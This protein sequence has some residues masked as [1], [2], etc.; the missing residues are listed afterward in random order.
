MI[1]LF[2]VVAFPVFAQEEHL[3][4][5]S[6][7]D[8]SRVSNISNISNLQDVIINREQ[9][10]G[11]P[12]MPTDPGRRQPSAGT[13]SGGDNQPR[14]PR[15]RREIKNREFD[16]AEKI[17]LL[18]SG[19]CDFPTREDLLNTSQNANEIL[20]NIVM[21]EDIL[22]SVRMR[23]VRAL[24]Y[25]QTEENAQ[26]LIEILNDHENQRTTLV[27]SAISGLVR[28][29]QADAVPYIAPFL[30]DSYDFIRFVTISSLK[31]C[32]GQEA[33]DALEERRKVETNRF[34]IYKLDDA[35]QN[36]CV[37]ECTMTQN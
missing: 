4:A 11:E 34:F 15:R 29:L 7:D 6:T 37:D 16:E 19:H 33:V 18:L 9:G 25:F 5:V 17:R 26:S 31:N 3:V 1:I 10:S 28:L 8:L 21:N 22:P 30:A 23:A 14:P 36:H 27:I 32:P 24:S 20:T 35:I 13:P 2:A 12:V